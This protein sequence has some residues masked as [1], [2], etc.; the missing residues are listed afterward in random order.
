MNVLILNGCWAPNIGNAFVNLGLE[1]IIKKLY[2]RANVIYSAELNNS[3]YFSLTTP[4]MVK[5]NFPITNYYPDIDLAIWGGMMLTK[6]FIDSGGKTFENLSANN[7]PILLIGAGGDKYDE[8]EKTAVLEFFKGL[9]NYSIITRDE[10]TYNLY[11]DTELFDKL[12]RGIDCA[13]FLPEI[14]KPPEMNYGEFDVECFDR[15]EVPEIDHEERKIVITHHEAYGKLPLGYINQPN[16]LLSEL[17]YD[18]I[19]LYANANSV[20]TERVHACIVAL[21]Y[22]NKAILYSKTP[23]KSLF[24]EVFGYDVD[25]QEKLQSL[26]MKKFREK[27]RTVLKTVKKKIK[28]LI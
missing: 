5:N 25:M 26:D 2:P 28:E 21:A 6:E 22:G 13:F 20:F 3:W 16:T 9:K 27:K 18:Y 1:G 7:V 4:E 17:P 24:K 23:R 10:L 14:V 12:D 11:K 15:I 19:N 8:E